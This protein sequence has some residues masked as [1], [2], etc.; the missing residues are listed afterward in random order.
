M[1]L[2]LQQKKTDD[3]VLVAEEQHTIR[4]FVEGAFKCVNKEI[5]WE[6]EGVNENR[7]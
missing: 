7:C 2:M 4:E 6:G 3:F 5:N 1:H